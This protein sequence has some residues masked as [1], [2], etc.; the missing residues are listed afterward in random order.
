M[1]SSGR[2]SHGEHAVARAVT[3]IES[4]PT[5]RAKNV[6]TSACSETTIALTGLHGACERHFAVAVVATPGMLS[7]TFLPPTLPP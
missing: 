5:I 2:V 4:M 6:C 1:M 7:R 3:P